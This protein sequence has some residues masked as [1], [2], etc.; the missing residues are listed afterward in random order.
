MKK[1]IAQAEELRAAFETIHI[2]AIYSSDLKRA[3]HTA[4]I[5]ANGREIQPVPRNSG[6][7]LR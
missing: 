7:I 5:I 3:D 4:E 2:D 6:V 1:G